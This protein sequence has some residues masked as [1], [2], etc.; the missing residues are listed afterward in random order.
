MTESQLSV[1]V[2]TYNGAAEIGSCLDALLSQ[3]TSDPFEILVVDDGSTDGTAE[4]V[5]R[6]PVRLVRHGDNRG[7][8]AARN[9]GIAAA[10]GSV[11]AFTDDDCVPQAGWVR[12]LLAPYSDRAVIGVGG[13]VVALETDNWLRRYLSLNNPLAP[14]EID[15]ADSS[16]FGHRLA[17]YL[18]RAWHPRPDPGPVRQV[19]SFVGANMSFR[20][21]ALEAIGCFDDTIHFGGEDEDVCVRVRERFSDRSLWFQPSAVICHNFDADMYDTL[22]RSYAY[23]RGSARAFVEARA[24]LPTVYPVPI[25]VALLLTVGLVRRRF[26]GAAMLAPLIAFP[27]WVRHLRSSRAEALLHPYIEC[28]QEAAHDVGFLSI[29]RA[30]HALTNAREAAQA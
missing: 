5:E 25:F 28:A 13:P 19:Y 11:L 2:C 17:L 9:T 4:L 10:T 30:R 12:S 15:L 22:R 6:Y 3:D 21:E 24:E 27:R 26:L 20:R 1:I 18:R 29:W 23:G 14:L 7:L 8:G 16:G